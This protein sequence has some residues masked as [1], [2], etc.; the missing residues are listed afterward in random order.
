MFFFLN[1]YLIYA[2]WLLVLDY[3]EHDNENQQINL[4][5]QRYTYPVKDWNEVQLNIDR[6]LISNDDWILTKNSQICWCTFHFDGITYCTCIN[7]FVILINIQNLKILSCYQIFWTWTDWYIILNKTFHE[8][9][10][11]LIK[12]E[13]DLYFRPYYWTWRWTT[14]KYC[15]ITERYLSWLRSS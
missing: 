12:F 15:M 9:Y 2:K 3:H 1:F 13:F 7:C 6:L 11:L 8:N 14:V 5:N 4:S 10:S